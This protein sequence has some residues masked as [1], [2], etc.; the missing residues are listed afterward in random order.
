MTIRTVCIYPFTESFSNS[1]FPAHAYKFLEDAVK[2]RENRRRLLHTLD[3]TSLVAIKSRHSKDLDL[4]LEVLNGYYVLNICFQLRHVKFL[5][6]DGIV[7][8]DLPGRYECLISM[9]NSDEPTASNQYANTSRS[10]PAPPSVVYEGKESGR[11]ASTSPQPTTLL[12]GPFWPIWPM[13]WSLKGCST[14]SGMRAMCLPSIRSEVLTFLDLSYTDNDTAWCQSFSNLPLEHLRILKLRGLRLT[15]NYL[16]R[17]GL[18]NGHNL[19]SV[20]LRDNFLTDGCIT[21]LSDWFLPML[22]LRSP[23]AS[24]LYRPPPRYGGYHESTQDEVVALRSD[25]KDD[26]M[27][28]MERNSHATDMADVDPLLRHTGLTHLY[29]AG[30]KITSNGVRQLFLLTN[31]L[32]VLDIGTVRDRSTFD[33]QFKSRH[34]ISWDQA[35][36]SASLGI[37]NSYSLSSLRIHHSIVTCMPTVTVASTGNEGARTPTSYSTQYLHAAEE[38][39]RSRILK[40]A[41]SF[42]PMKNCIIETL[43]LTG[44]P[45]KSYGYLIEKL[46]A[47]LAACRKQEEELSKARVTTNRRAPQVLPGLKT[48]RLEF[49]PPDTI[50][51]TPSRGRGS[52]SG[53]PDAEAFS[54][55]SDEDFSFFAEPMDR[56]IHRLS[57]NSGENSEL[58]QDSAATDETL[59]DVVEE[60]KRARREAGENKWGGNLELV[61][62]HTRS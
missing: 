58:G 62:P 59:K 11:Q 28:H 21:S 42:V 7:D 44:I 8:W 55:A 3:F 35:K 25:T 57:W 31:R 50:E 43:T 46:I 14:I 47:F 36:M 51:A 39:A 16:P 2:A 52:I 1:S 32:N 23:F 53:D 40:G 38:I 60:L 34:A 20:D 4:H 54:A 6:M 26:F 19:W 5:I 33:T 13:L 30:N 10:T 29:I 18:R 27:Q 37:T 22:P 48:L 17:L 24:G 56:P 15:D 49:L 61:L 12:R 45:T 41:T 9:F